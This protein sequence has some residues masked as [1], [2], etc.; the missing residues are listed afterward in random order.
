VVVSEADI[1]IER[2]LRICQQAM[3]EALSGFWFLVSGFW[4]LVSGFRG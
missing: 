4:F 2:L 3:T 1:M